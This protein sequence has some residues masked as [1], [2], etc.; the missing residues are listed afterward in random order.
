MKLTPGDGDS[1]ERGQ[2]GAND[3]VNVELEAVNAGV[4]AQMAALS[5]KAKPERTTR[6]M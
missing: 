2:A 3:A 5:S 6:R 1:Y 4:N